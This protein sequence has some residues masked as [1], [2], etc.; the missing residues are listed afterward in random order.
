M[1]LVT[2]G[3]G[4]IGSH[5]VR[6]LLD[7]GKDCFIPKHQEVRD[8]T[9]FEDE[10]NKRIFIEQVDLSKK[11]ELL[12]LGDKYDITGIVHLAAPGFGG[13][14]TQDFRDHVALLTNVLDAAEAWGVKRVTFASALGVYAGITELPWKEDAPL[15]LIAPAPIVAL[16]KIS[17]ITANFVNMSDKV[18]CVALRI[19]A[20]FGPLQ[21]PMITAANR[22]AHAAA[23]GAP[24]KLEGTVFTTYAQEGFDYC[25]VKDVARGIA[26]L[27]TAD[28]LNHRIYNVASGQATTNQT[29]A[30][31]VKA[32]HPNLEISLPEGKDPHGIGLVP[33][34]DITRLREDTGYGPQFGIREAMEDYI[35]WLQAGHKQ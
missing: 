29:V 10:L 15:S 25:Y 6:A 34:M 12:A 26:L 20:V 33:A 17:E 31:A 7:A 18:E 28:K 35:A 32:L 8:V 1:I 22:L 14:F 2:G 19:A 27:Q 30:D 5:T 11:D 16:K 9:F 21:N 13:A 23:T 3:A 24:V 4:F